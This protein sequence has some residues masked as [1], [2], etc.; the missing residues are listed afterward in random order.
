[1]VQNLKKIIMFF[2][3]VQLYILPSAHSAAVDATVR[4]LLVGQKVTSVNLK[5]LENKNINPA[6]IK[7]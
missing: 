4:P 6:Q 5:S 3:L 7:A 1:M 2:L